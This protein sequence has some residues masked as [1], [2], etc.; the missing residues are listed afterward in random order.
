MA[1]TELYEKVV[2]KLISLNRMDLGIF[3]SLLGDNSQHH[4]FEILYISSVSSKYKYRTNL[5]V[6]DDYK[7]EDLIDNVDFEELDISTPVNRN[8]LEIQK[9]ITLHLLYDRI[10]IDREY[11]EIYTQK[12]VELIVSYPNLKVINDGKLKFKVGSFDH[13]DSLYLISFDHVLET[14]ITIDIVTL[15]SNIVFDRMIYYDDNID[16]LIKFLKD[17][18]VKKLIIEG[19]FERGAE[20][21][22]L[23]LETA[24]PNLIYKT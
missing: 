17:A 4:K 19:H 24:F 6:L 20:K 7:K 3:V 5:L 15:A 11:K 18:Q 10:E 23:K 21:E 12:D 8:L 1:S 9:P 13:I 16:I 22:K 2:N 14:E